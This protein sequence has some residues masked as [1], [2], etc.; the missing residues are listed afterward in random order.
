[1]EPTILDCGH[2]LV[3]PSHLGTGYAR[4]SDN[5]QICYACAT[6]RQIEE[7]KT[8]TKFGGYLSGGAVTDWGGGVL[9]EVTGHVRKTMQRAPNGSRYELVTFRAKDKH[10]AL[11][12]CRGTGEGMLVHM[13]RV[14]GA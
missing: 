4:T 13:R 1:M 2:E 7:M 8:A 14:K 11:W 3:K 9:A 12:S 5:K 6:A 10:G